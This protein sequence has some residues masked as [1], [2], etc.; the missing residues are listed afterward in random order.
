MSA[1]GPSEREYFKKI[2]KRQRELRDPEV[3]RFLTHWLYDAMDEGPRPNHDALNGG[4]APVDWPGWEIYAPPLGKGCM[5]DVSGITSAHARR[6]L[7][8]G[9]A[10][11]LTKN[12]PAGAGP[13]PGWSRKELEASITAPRKSSTSKKGKTT[14]REEAQLRFFEEVLKPVIGAQ[15][16]IPVSELCSRITGASRT[17]VL[18]A[19]D[20]AS[21]KGHV[22]KTLRDNIMSVR[23]SLM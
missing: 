16:G 1:K 12:M 15:P 8:S 3:A 7:E 5:C 11:D 20:S 19:L 22:V 18:E 2:I 6:M 10:F 21:L 23:L 17:K 4:I 9:E 13:D 14:R